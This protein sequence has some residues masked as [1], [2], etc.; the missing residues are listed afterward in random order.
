MLPDIFAG[1]IHR[2]GICEKRNQGDYAMLL[3]FARS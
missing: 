1:A 2:D 3:L